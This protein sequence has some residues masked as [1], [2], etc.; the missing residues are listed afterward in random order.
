[1]QTAVG[2]WSSVSLRAHYL[3]ISY[4]AVCRSVCWV[5]LGEIQENEIDFVLYLVS[6]VLLKLH[7]GGF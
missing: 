7:Q 4:V 2:I 5:V 1:M 3:M 6:K